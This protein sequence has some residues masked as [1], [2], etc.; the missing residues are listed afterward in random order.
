MLSEYEPISVCRAMA[1]KPSAHGPQYNP[2][3]LLEK[4]VLFFVGKGGVGKTTAACAT[5]IA[6]LDRAKGDDRIHLFST[7]PAHSLADSLGKA[8][9]PHS[10][11][12]ARN[13][14]ASLHA[15]QM[16]PASAFQ[17]F[18]RQFGGPVAE[19]LEH[20]TF[21][22]R[23]EIDEFA[24]FTPP[25]IDEVMALFQLS[26]IIETGQYTH[27][28]VDTA[29]AGHTLRLLE[30]PGVFSNWLAA[31]DALEDKH[32]FMVLQLARRRNA[33][34]IDGFFGDFYARITAVKQ[35]ISDPV[36]S[37]FV[38]VTTPEPIVREETV[39]FFHFLRQNQIPITA[40]VINRVQ[41][42]IQ[43][44][45]YC[46]ARA[47][48][49]A[50]VLRELKRIFEELTPALVPLFPGEVRGPG[51]LRSFSRF[52][53]RRPGPLPEPAPRSKANRRR[54]P[55]RLKREHSAF[56][57]ECHRVLIFGGKGG[58]GKTT[59]ASAAALT[60]A[61]MFPGSPVVVLSTDPAH[62]LSD[63]FGEQIGELK[64]GLAGLPNLDGMEIDS[65]ARFNAFRHRYESW[66][67]ELFT[68]L[69]AGSCW[70]I[71]FDREATTKLLTL[72]P[73]GIDEI[74]A[75]TT[76]ASLLADQ[77]YE[78]IVVDTAPSGHLLRL[79][80]LPDVALS[81]L[82]ALIKL[83]LKYKEVIHWGDLAAELVSLSKGIK[84]TLSLL[85]DSSRTEFVG[86]A[87]PEKM[88]LEETFRLY[89]RLLRLGI[90]VSRLL[91]N[92]LIPTEDGRRCDFC[93][94]RRSQQDDVLTSYRERFPDMRIFV[95]P[96]QRR[97]VQGPARLR[98]HFAGWSRQN[99]YD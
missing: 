99:D 32:R 14:R 24:G 70:T 8:I 43:T 91:I 86:V 41:P 40:V 26:E 82:R 84:N 68:S 78:N 4:R 57:L 25:G 65:F 72:A 7:D 27:I 10:R 33:D 74:F 79:L 71:A 53:W 75:L 85:R 19:I 20:G 51:L 45:E 56:D 62:S 36:R 13:R 80:E 15:C 16:D 46:R 3:K 94:A 9:G 22:D 59:A 28:V 12:I 44:C 58:V 30:L 83:M 81:W 54:S 52:A 31:L 38:L 5:A 89:G 39:R 87:I 21:L 95:A 11:L 88:S 50:P 55:R 96:E 76:I 90:P 48:A 67:D 73:P 23:A 66:I 1:R 63:A 77:A 2:S 61:E 98:S 6:L 69:T 47:R 49:Q 34:P 17:D 37:G 64:K 29:P 92:N 60:L 42:A 97:P 35:M 93:S 18:K